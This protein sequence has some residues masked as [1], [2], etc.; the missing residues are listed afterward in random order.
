MW[1]PSPPSIPAPSPKNV[2]ISG[3]PPREGTSGNALKSPSPFKSEEQQ[4]ELEAL[5]QRGLAKLLNKHFSQETQRLA[6]EK[7]AVDAA[8]QDLEERKRQ[9][10]N[11]SNSKKNNV[12]SNSSMD[13]MYHK[14]HQMRAENRQKEKETLLLYQR[15]VHKFG[16]TGQVKSPEKS[17]ADKSNSASMPTVSATTLSTPSKELQQLQ[18]QGALAKVKQETTRINTQQKAAASPAILGTKNDEDYKQ[19]YAQDDEENGAADQE[20]KHLL[21]QYLQKQ[22]DKHGE[23]FDVEDDLS[24]LISGLTSVDSATT[25]QILL[26]CELTVA[27]FL[28]EE[29]KAI[30]EEMMQ[31]KK[32]QD[33]NKVDSAR[34]LPPPTSSSRK[35]KMKSNQQF[36][37]SRSVGELSATSTQTEIQ[38]HAALEA[39]SMAQQMQQILKDF[40]TGAV[41]DPT[42]TVATTPSSDSASSAAKKGKPFP[43]ANPNEEWVVLYDDHYQREYYHETRS[44]VTQWHAPDSTAKKE[45]AI[46][47]EDVM[48]ETQSLASYQ[49]DRIRKYRIRRKRRR[50]RRILRATAAVLAVLGAGGYYYYN[51]YNVSTPPESIEQS[52]APSKAKS[53][54]VPAEV[55]VPEKVTSTTSDQKV[56]KTTAPT[57]VEKPVVEKPKETLKKEAPTPKPEQNIKPKTVNAASVIPPPRPAGCNV[58]FSYLVHGGCRKLASENPLFT[59]EDLPFLQ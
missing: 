9:A 13:D 16:F 6:Q 57:K 11:N 44:G 33:Q 52:T 15:Y 19:I 5:R 53:A 21:E 24:S 55:R 20:A 28:D 43:T 10:K 25:R 59:P 29:R 12:V 23:E 22:D 39:E 31:K 2:S 36:S 14:I 38:T 40:E 35:T 46:D 48:P 3:T 18:E 26:D 56:H 30:Q 37:S 4:A 8:L 34:S 54:R 49:S 45:Q 1:N 32:K 51:H 27:T 7:K 47:Y 50:R 42:T 17:A 58:P 41:D